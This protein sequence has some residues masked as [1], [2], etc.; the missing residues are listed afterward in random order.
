MGTEI[1]NSDSTDTKYR[2]RRSFI[3]AI[4]LA[5]I[6]EVLPMGQAPVALHLLSHLCEKVGGVF[7]P[8]DDEPDGCLG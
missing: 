8:N 5:I 3:T 6:T 2:I 1:D 4:L 7:F